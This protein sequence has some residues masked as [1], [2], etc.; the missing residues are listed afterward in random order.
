LYPRLSAGSSDIEHTTEQ[1]AGENRLTSRNGS[2]SQAGSI[3]WHGE[4]ESIASGAAQ[5]AS[6]LLAAQGCAT[7][8][9]YH[10]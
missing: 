10:P 6:G 1:P 5:S 2:R 3:V 4:L 8:Y 7:P 9:R